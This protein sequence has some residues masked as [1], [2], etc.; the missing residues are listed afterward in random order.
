MSQIVRSFRPVVDN[1]TCI[2]CGN[3]FTECPFDAIN[4]VD[5]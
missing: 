3:C 5:L 4:V 1:E 2:K